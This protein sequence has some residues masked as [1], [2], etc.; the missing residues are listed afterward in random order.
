MIIHYLLIHKPFYGL[1]GE[2][3]ANISNY[4]IKLIIN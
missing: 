4:I 1:I 2:K 3:Q